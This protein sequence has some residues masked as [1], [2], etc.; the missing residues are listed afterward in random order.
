MERMEENRLGI[1][2]FIFSES[3]FMGLLILAYGYFLTFPKS[4]PSPQ[5]NLDPLVAGFFTLGLILSS[6][7][8]W[9]AVRSFAQQAFGRFAAW[10]VV[11][12]LLGAAFLVGTGISWARLI[13]KNITISTNTF[14]T[15]FFTVTGFHVAHLVVGMAILGILFGLT[16]AGKLQGPKSAAVDVSG[17]YWYFVVVLSVAVYGAVYLTFVI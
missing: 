8:M 7:S 4:G 2:L 14:S 12:F 10:L 17:L 16:L 5:D 13:G 9:Q 6:F 1:L 3:A 15:T 11:T